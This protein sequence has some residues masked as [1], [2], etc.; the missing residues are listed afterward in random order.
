MEDISNAL[1]AFAAPGAGQSIDLDA[2][3]AMARQ[4]MDSA[5]LRSREETTDC[6]GTHLG[7]PIVFDLGLL[8]AS[9]RADEI[10]EAVTSHLQMC[11]AKASTGRGTLAGN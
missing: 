8:V 3:N 7:P 2:R 5:G 6:S 9:D 4:L 10:A 11:T 1:K